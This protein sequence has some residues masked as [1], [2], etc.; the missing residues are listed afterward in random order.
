MCTWHFEAEKDDLIMVTVER[1]THFNWNQGGIFLA[2]PDRMV[3]Q[4]Q[5]R[6]GGLEFQS[7]AQKRF[8]SI[9]NKMNLTL[10]TSRYGVSSD[11]IVL[12]FSYAVFRG[13]NIFIC[14]IYVLFDLYHT[15]PPPPH[16]TDNS[17]PTN[18]FKKISFNYSTCASNT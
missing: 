16:H 9:G 13:T 2:S 5:G 1:L 4:F 7:M 11:E 14:I 3:R 15:P 10:F 12:R 17:Q 8:T 18:T 6:D